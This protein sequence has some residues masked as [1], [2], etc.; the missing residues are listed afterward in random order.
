MKRLRHA[1]QVLTPAALSRML[2][3]G[4]A[5]RGRR[6]DS[7]FEWS[8]DR[9]YCSELVWKIYQRALGLELGKLQ[10]MA[11]F[12][13]SDPLVRSIAEE[14]WHGAPPANEPVITPAAIFESE[15]LVVVHRR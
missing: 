10:T 4:E 3:A 12:D 11:T 15:D 6:Y 1:D 8:D 9:L 2:E 14:R 13:F 7:W 5:F